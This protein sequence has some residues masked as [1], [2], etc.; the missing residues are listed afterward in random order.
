[1]SDT[2]GAAASEAPAR[3]RANSTAHSS[4]DSTKSVTGAA[5]EEGRITVSVRV[6]PLNARETKLNT[7]SC[8]ATRPAYNTLYILPNGESEQEVSAMI[9]V[10]P[11]LRGTRHHRF[12]F[13]HVYPVDS[14]QEQVFEQ[15][16]RP[17]LQSSFRGYHTCIFTY[18]QTGSGKSYCMMGADG[19]RSI[20]DDPGIIPRLC[21]EVF[22][23]VDRQRKAA[24]ANGTEE[25]DFSVYVSYLEIYRERVR[26]LLDEVLDAKLVA[27]GADGAGSASPRLPSAPVRRPAAESADAT[28]RVREHPTLGVY[29]EGLAE[30]PVTS[31]EQVLRLMVRGNQRRHTASTRMNDT[32]SRSHAIFTVQ[33]L[34]KRTHVVPPGEGGDGANPDGGGLASTVVTMTTQLGAKINLVDL[35][36]SERAKATGA[37]GETLKEG[38][39]INKS[40]TTLGIVI[41]A[42]AAQSTASASAAAGSPGA[43][44]M[45]TSRRHIPYRDSTLTFLLKESLGGN[46]KTF[47]IATVSPST[48]NYEE[49]LSTLR[50]ADRAK[51]IMMKAFVN[52]TAGDKRIRELEEEVTRLREQ[53]RSLIDADT[54]RSYAARAALT[55]GPIVLADSESPVRPSPMQHSILVGDGDRLHRGTSEGRSLA[56]DMETAS[57]SERGASPQPGHP[58]PPPPPAE[59]A[60]GSVASPVQPSSAES[61]SEVVETLQSELRRAE[62]L[63]RQMSESEAER[64]AHMAQLVQRHEREQAAARA[65]ASEMAVAAAAAAKAAAAAAAAKEVEKVAATGTMR[66]RRDEPYLLNMDGAGDWVVA[67][68]GPTETHVG[69]FAARSRAAAEADAVNSGA[70][71]DS[72]LELSSPRSTSPGAASVSDDTTVRYVR[73]PREFGDGV[74]GPHFILERAPAG[75]AAAATGQ[76]ST[77][78]RG[79]PGCDTYVVRPMHRSPFVV[80]GGDTLLLQSGDVVDIGVDHIQLK[81]MDPAEPPVTARGRRTVRMDAGHDSGTGSA[82]ISP[83]S[84]GSRQEAALQSLQLPPIPSGQ[85]R[86]DGASTH[87]GPADAEHAGESGG[88]DDDDDVAPHSDYD[89]DEDAE[90]DGDDRSRDGS[91]SDAEAERVVDTATAPA[92]LLLP[93]RPLIPA[94]AL[95]KAIPANR[96]T[97]PPPPPLSEQQRTSSAAP[98]DTTSTDADDTTSSWMEGD[99]AAVS[100]MAGATATATATAAPAATTPALSLPLHRLRAPGAAAPVTTAPPVLKTR[101]PSRRVPQTAHLNPNSALS[102]SEVQAMRTSASSTTYRSELPP[103]F[104]GRYNLVLVGPCGSGKSSI[105]RNLQT[106]D[107]PWLQSAFSVFTGGGSGGGAESKA[108]AAAATLPPTIGIQTTTLAVAGT[109]PVGLHVHELGGT[110]CFGP[111]LD[112][113]PSH[114]VAYFLCFPLHAGPPLM[115]LRG[116]VEDILCRTDSHTVSL[117]LVGTHAHHSSAAGGKGGDGGSGGGLF[118]NRLSAVRQAMLHA[119]MEE[120]ELQV[121]SLMQMLQPYPQLRPTV[122]GRF[123]VDNVHRQVYATG[124]RAVE[125]FAEWLQW[126]G[127]IARDRCRADVDFAGGLVPARCVELGRQVGMLRERGKWCLS[128]R[129]FKTLATAVS[130]QYEASAAAEG[131][132]ARDTLRH[133]VQL[134]ADWGVLAH[135]FRSTPLRQH[136]VLDVMWL[137]RVLTTLACSPLVA[138]A[139]S[140]GLTS[141]EASAL[142]DVIGERGVALLTRKEVALRILLSPEAER[143][144]DVVKVATTDTPHLLR[145]GVVTMPV[146]VTMLEPHFTVR[147]GSGG[148][149]GASRSAAR[150]VDKVGTARG[151]PAPADTGYS[152]PLAGV[153]ELLVLCDHIIVGHKL[154]LSPSAAEAQRAATAPSP[155]HVPAGRAGSATP[156]RRSSTADA[157]ADG[158]IDPASESFVVYPMSCRTPASAG[159]T[160]LFPCF[161]SGPFYVFKL[162]MVPRNFFPKLLCRLATVS[163]KIYMGPV[164]AQSWG[165][166]T[167]RWAMGAARGRAATTATTTAAGPFDS[168]FTQCA[169]K[170]FVLPRFSTY[171]THSSADGSPRR[172]DGLWFDAAWLVY[173]DA[174]RGDDGE[175]DN[176]RVLVRLVHHSVFL[177]FH[178]HQAASSSGLGGDVGGAS[179]GVQDFYEAVLEAVRHVVEEF[180]GGKC[181][182]SMQ[183]C[184]D[185]ATLLEMELQHPALQTDQEAAALD[186]HVR[187]ANISDNLNNLERVLAK[188]GAA[189]RTARTARRSHASSA[190]ADDDGEDEGAYVPLL[191]NFRVAP[192]LDIAACLRRW[193]AEQRFHISA[194][195]EGRLVDALQTLGACY[196]GAS[197][198]SG[199]SCF[200]LDRL[201]DVLACVDTV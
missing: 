79:C 69:V 29:V 107:T 154:L 22:V 31:E 74:G 33:L 2:F 120:V 57:V 65:A 16:G 36:G 39:Q 165:G 92:A 95:G 153:L 52:E 183:C 87:P 41:N 12:T 78:L 191:R 124:Y 44:S 149:S 43:R 86:R 152:V 121:I 144:I 7:G 179:S 159:V 68:L 189:L 133:H 85:R 53:I 108:G 116:L 187:F 170:S 192:Q 11:H 46:S 48:D 13:D 186:R 117:V 114:R 35:A 81:Y 199:N 147:D 150:A 137:C 171:L 176:C 135:R 151:N 200:A 129:D 111:L 201:L 55:I 196:T 102:L 160:W 51:A 145:Y 10:D 18:G 194:E 157:D 190:A 19:G 168:Y 164:Q 173:R 32:S 188:S 25:V 132:L 125:G 89:D 131:S 112:Q 76:S 109:S 175:D 180:P 105:V 26:S 72:S 91:S 181:S 24:E 146:L 97:P 49:S 37:E 166:P 63:I 8:I 198:S 119:Q 27:G 93:T 23:E 90:G 104:V 138:A 50:Y 113:L 5:Y 142:T 20:D 184:A 83:A 139:S 4:D 96:L 21:R 118:S 193:K 6:R 58:P 174:D 15:I 34:Q 128:L 14:T 28:L 130:S 56:T 127:D 9:A 155:P 167:Q 126:L 197:L 122:V 178:C 172:R 47:M 148:A 99:S 110:P 169:G 77:V 1:M 54:R 82:A 73:L 71:C 45:G 40:L 30:I 143:V 61:A 59:D 17:V 141:A 70:S 84:A 100:P 42:L 163:D 3:S 75:D 156:P 60:D 115:A 134:L 80:K 101:V 67:H 103:R 38:A 88:S 162:D 161:L 158:E 123:A 140:D 98:C 62:M 66:L 182:E 177:S 106:P 136:V 195:V 94:L 64:T 185:P